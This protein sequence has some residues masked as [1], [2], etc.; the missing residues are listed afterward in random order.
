MLLLLV[1]CVVLTTAQQC[2]KTAMEEENFDPEK[3]AGLWYPGLMSPIVSNVFDNFSV[4]F[5]LSSDGNSVIVT[6]SLNILG[7]HIPITEEADWDTR[8]GNANFTVTFKGFL[9][10]VFSGTYVITCTDYTSYAIVHG[11]TRL[12]P[13]VVYILYREEHPDRTTVDA[14]KE[15]LKTCAGDVDIVVDQSVVLDYTE[16]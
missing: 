2:Q 11:C 3:F 4:N 13:D 1:T 15:Q 9:N 16:K 5:E 10:F 8:E 14:S 12:F 7:L 6:N